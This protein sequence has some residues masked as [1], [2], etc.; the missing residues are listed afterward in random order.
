MQFIGIPADATTEDLLQTAKE[1][2]SSTGA[3]YL[4]IAPNQELM[5]LYLNQVMSVPET[6]FL[7]KEGNILQSFVGSRSKSEWKELIEEAYQEVK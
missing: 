5:D 4:Q 7:D 1:I 3:D 6:L 2:A